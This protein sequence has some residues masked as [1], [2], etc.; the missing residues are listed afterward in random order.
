MANV[1]EVYQSDSKWLSA[2]DLKGREI[3]LA[4]DESKVEEVGEN[5]KLVVYFKG[6]DKGLALNKTN[7]R[8][9]A[10]SYGKDSDDWSGKEI[11]L[12]PTKTEFQGKLVDCIRVRIPMAAALDDEIPFEMSWQ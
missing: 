8:M 11:I 3:K 2:P 5:H 9:I 4:I 12:Y 10:E 6:K 1:D 7:A